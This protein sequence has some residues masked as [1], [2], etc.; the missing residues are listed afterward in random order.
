VL[1]AKG[2]R[3]SAADIEQLL[4]SP[5]DTPGQPIVSA[6]IVNRQGFSDGWLE[7]LTGGLSF[8]LHG[9]VP[10]V[11]LVAPAARHVFGLS[12]FISQSELDAI[13][14]YPGPH[15]VGGA[16]MLPVVRRMASL[17]S[18]LA[19]R[20]DAAAICWEP[21]GSWMDPNYFGR[22]MSSW[23]DGG[24]FPA[25]G[26]TGIDRLDDGIVETTGLTYFI[27]QEL[28][29]KTAS[30]VAPAAAIKLAVRLIDH[31]VRFGS[32]AGQAELV[33]PDGEI[34][35]TQHSSDGARVT[36]WQKG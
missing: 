25:L 33:G 35:A 8:D 12:S 36:I 24:A 22:V 29:L 21:S 19:L 23:N 34:F 5:A 26:L 32:L 6:Q 3:P 27:G 11:G 17:A 4:T 15:L 9:L 31:L 7:L 16:A 13:A 2:R 30:S 20:L 10:A 18:Q 28:R 1:L 14:L